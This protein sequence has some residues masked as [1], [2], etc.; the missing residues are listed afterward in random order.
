MAF[1][2]TYSEANASATAYN[3]FTITDT[4]DYTDEPKVDFTDRRVYLVMADG[5]Y[6]QDETTGLDYFDFAFADYPTD[7]ITI[8]VLED[9]DMS[10]NVY[11]LWIPTTPVSGSTYYAAGVFEFKDNAEDF[12]WNKILQLAANRTLWSNKNF[13]TTLSAAR[14]MIDSSTTSVVY[15]DQYASQVCINFVGEVENTPNLFY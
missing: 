9:T 15:Q 10:L 4:S 12:M 11:L 3:A 8:N 1:T 2:G 6:V 13:R 7:E 14:C 5:T